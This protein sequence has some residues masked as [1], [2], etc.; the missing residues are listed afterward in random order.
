MIERRTALLPVR[1]IFNLFLIIA[2]LSA[3]QAGT[4]TTIYSF[5]SSPNDGRQPVAGVTIGPGGVLYGTTEYG[6]SAGCGVNGCGTAFSLTPPASPGGAWTESVYLFTGT[7]G[8]YPLGGLTFGLDGLVL[9]GTAEYGGT[10]NCLGAVFEL[11]PPSASGSWV[12]TPLLSGCPQILNEPNNTPVIGPG[13]VIYITTTL[14][15]ADGLAGTVTSLTPPASPGDSWTETLVKGFGGTRG[16][17]IYPFG[18]AIGSN[19]ALYGVTGGGGSESGGSHGTVYELSPPTTPG[20]A[21]TETVLHRFDPNNGDGAQPL[22]TLL[23]GSGGEL[24]GTTELGGS[25]NLGT[26]FSL[27]PP[28]APGGGKYA[29]LHS[30]TGTSKSDGAGPEGPLLGVGGLLYGT[31]INGGSSPCPSGCGTIFSLT[32]PASAGGV[33]TESVVHS[34]N[35]LD[36]AHPRGSLTRGRDGTLYGTTTMGGHFN[37]GTVFAFTP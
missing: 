32:P 35:G 8:E 4:L 28:A 11:R 16:G 26:V 9:Y 29:V 23:I 19:G 34:F 22:A 33:W 21:W 13:G 14:G 24:F 30:F 36:G 31:T 17:G 6:G 5:Q 7:N 15:P 20:A 37:D 3:V 10:V 27:V 25:S 12:E 2:S 1:T 18:I